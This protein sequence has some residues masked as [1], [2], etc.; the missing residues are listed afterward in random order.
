MC[1]KA[2]KWFQFAPGFALHPTPPAAARLNQALAVP[3]TQHLL[4]SRNRHLK[5]VLFVFVELALRYCRLYLVQCQHVQR[6]LLQVHL[7]LASGSVPV[8]FLQRQQSISVN[9]WGK[10]S[11][12][13]YKLKVLWVSQ[14]LCKV[15]NLNISGSVRAG[16]QV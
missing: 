15:P 8:T 1:I 7:M 12:A 11:P 10:K 6:R 4:C 5:P 14:S 3:R 2:N 16:D 13:P 9:L